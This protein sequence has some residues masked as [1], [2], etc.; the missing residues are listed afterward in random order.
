MLLQPLLSP[1]PSIP[2]PHQVRQQ[3]QKQNNHPQNHISKFIERFENAQ[4][5]VTILQPINNELPLI[6]LYK[7]VKVVFCH[8]SLPDG[9]GG[10]EVDVDAFRG[11]GLAGQRKYAFLLHSGVVYVRQVHVVARLLVVYCLARFFT[12]FAF[13]WFGCLRV[14][15]RHAVV[16]TTTAEA[17]LSGQ[18]DAIFT[19]HR[20]AGV[21]SHTE[22]L[23][24]VIIVI[25]RQMHRPIMRIQINLIHQRVHNRRNII[26]YLRSKR[27]ISN[28]K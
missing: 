3:E 5:I 19:R 8:K 23:Y 16:V 21:I 18:L 14:D 2:Q 15:W 6:P 22:N 9:N 26:T 10:F 1:N 13:L 4:V 20:V 12:A 17:D 7:R 11:F 24:K 28:Q 25:V 27:R